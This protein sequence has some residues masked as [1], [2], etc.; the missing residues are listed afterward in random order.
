MLGS[1]ADSRSSHR[2]QQPPCFP[3]HRAAIETAPSRSLARAQNLGSIPH[4]CNCKL[5]D[6]LRSR[7]RSTS[8]YTLGLRLGVGNAAEQWAA[9]KTSYVPPPNARHTIPWQSR[10]IQE[11]ECVTTLLQERRGRASQG[12]KRARRLCARLTPGLLNKRPSSTIPPQSTTTEM[13]RGSLID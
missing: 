7:K 4:V 8:F 9:L 11:V 13:E 12:F 1:Q 3:Q 2:R 5:H 10:P 6:F